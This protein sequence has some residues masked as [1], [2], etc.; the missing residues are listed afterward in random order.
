MLLHWIC[1]QSTFPILSAAIKITLELGEMFRGRIKFI[2][3]QIEREISNKVTARYFTALRSHTPPKKGGTLE[4]LQE[5]SDHFK[6]GFVYFWGGG[7]GLS[8]T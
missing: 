2:S 7:V 4:A 3:K 8:Y 5:T 6:K 1:I